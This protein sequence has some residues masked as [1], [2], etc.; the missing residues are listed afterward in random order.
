MRKVEMRDA[1]VPKGCL[2]SFSGVSAEAGTRWIDMYTE[3]TR[4]S[5]RYVQ[6]GGCTSVGAAG[7]FIQG[8]GFGSFSK[9]FGIACAGV[10]EYEVVTADGKVLVAND[11]QNQ[12]FFWALKGG[13]KETWAPFKRWLAQYP[14][15]YTVEISTRYIPPN[16]N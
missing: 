2:K 8:G 16:K 11:D 7:G 15:S 13:V 12:A 10:L 9:K 3:V 14:D 4:K 5:G 1:F 6:G